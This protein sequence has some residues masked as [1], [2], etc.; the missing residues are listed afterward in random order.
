[1]LINYREAFWWLLG[2][3]VLL[4]FFLLLRTF[5]S[6]NLIISAFTQFN[7]LNTL[8][9]WLCFSILN[10]PISENNTQNRKGII[11]TEGSQGRIGWLLRAIGIMVCWFALEAGL[12]YLLKEHKEQEELIHTISKLVSGTFGGLA[13][14]LFI[15]RFQSKFLKSSSRLIVV[16]YLYTVIQTLFI[17]FGDDSVR[18]EIWAACVIFAALVLKA[19]LILYMFWLFQSG[20]LLFYLVRVR[21]AATQVDIEWQ[22]FREVLKREN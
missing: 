4:Y 22:D 2:A 21:R 11:I 1:V 9:I 19:L 3:W 18:A 7:N 20:R 15:G 12:A 13:M 6:G 14:A 16:L 10:E 17:F 8:C 5:L